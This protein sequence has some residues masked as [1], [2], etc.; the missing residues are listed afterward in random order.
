MPLHFFSPAVTHHV[1]KLA[2]K[3]AVN[4][5]RD[6]HALAARKR[7][8]RVEQIDRS[9]ARRT[10]HLSTYHEEHRDYQSALQALPR[11]DAQRQ[12]FAAS[13]PISE[14]LGQILNAMRDRG[15]GA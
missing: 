14:T 10:A 1:S 12:Q 3:E 15:Y 13:P 11:L 8:A 4:I 2:R 9:I 7:Q 5:Y 6:A